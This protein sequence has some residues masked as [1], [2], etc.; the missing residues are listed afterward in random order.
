MGGCTK[1]IWIENHNSDISEQVFSV[2]KKMSYAVLGTLCA[3][4]VGFPPVS[5]A[6]IHS[7]FP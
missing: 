4:E 7:K 2:I 6:A 5:G 3:V 1:L